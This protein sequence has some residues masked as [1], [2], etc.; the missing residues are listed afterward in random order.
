VHKHSDYLFWNLLLAPDEGN[1]PSGTTTNEGGE[2][3]EGSP[4]IEPE[5]APNTEN[6]NTPEVD[7]DYSK[8]DLKISDQVDPTNLTSKAFS[9]KAKELGVSVETAKALFGVVDTSLIQSKKDYE[10]SAK[11]RCEATLKE[12][13]KGDY[14]SNN[15]ALAR[16]FLKLT[17]SDESFK[18]ELET[19]GLLDNPL[20]AEIVSRVGYFFKEEGQDGASTPTFDKN[21]PYGFVKDSK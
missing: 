21:D 1:N 16:G 5:T 6:T 10:Q 12:K 4:P 2:T 18:N 8:F 13:W 14:E 3:G 19:N 7:L 9:D 20:L 15:K 17:E 11:E